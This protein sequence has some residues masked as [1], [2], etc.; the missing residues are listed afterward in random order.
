MEEHYHE[1]AG[2][3]YSDAQLSGYDVLPDDMVIKT[4]LTKGE[5]SEGF[6]VTAF[7]VSLYNMYN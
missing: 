1:T 6:E 7:P 3:S 4:F 2:T 5:A